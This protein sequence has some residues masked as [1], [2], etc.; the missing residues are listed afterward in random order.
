MVGLLPGRI[1]GFIP[2]EG[3]GGGGGGGGG[4]LKSKVAYFYNFNN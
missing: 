4:E 1:S 2:G 3:G